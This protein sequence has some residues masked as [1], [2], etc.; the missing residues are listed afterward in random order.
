MTG[1]DSESTF[2]AME[3]YV[4]YGGNVI[5]IDASKPVARAVVIEADRISYVGSDREAFAR[6]PKNAKHID[7][8]GKT[9]IPGFNDNHIHTLAMG[10]FFS[11]P[12]LHGFN[13]PGIIELLKAAFSDVKP[14]KLLFALGWDYPSCP[15]PHRSL[16]DVAFPQNPLVLIQF[17]GHGMWL[18]S[19]AL[20][21]F[22]I[23][24]E[25][26]DPVGGT[27]LRDK[28]GEPTGIL[29]DAATRPIHRVRYRRMH[30][31]RGHSGH[32]LD[33]ALENLREAGITSVQDNT[34]YPVTLRLLKSY[35]RSGLLTCRF[36]CWFL[37]MQPFRSRL[38]QIQ[39]VDGIW[40][41]R[42]P[43]KYFLD[44]TFTTKT[45]YLIEPYSNDGG[46]FGMRDPVFGSLET[47]LIHAAR[48]RR[49]LAFHAIGDRAVHE[50]LNSFGRARQKAP[51]ISDL[52]IR[53]EHAQ[54]IH[55]DDIPRI[56]DLGIIIS[57]QPSALG[58]PE[59]DAA[60]LGKERA[61]AAYPYRS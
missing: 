44:G 28:S 51:H 18:N 40:I 41:S 43:W 11:L 1:N 38:M 3:G 10:E 60:L 22:G 45:A 30:S 53:L 39:P 7:L 20:K 54:L 59:K 55:P 47:L 16:L 4:L 52:R 26:P 50:F 57:A 49:Q 13:G 25:T 8:R 5:T 17:S 33:R 42:G 46:N 15:E 9:L 32:L 58:T 37:G 48:K 56:R 27:I 34:W 36:T 2:T 21:L 35:R 61:E 6:A 29:R 12:R 14:G 23:N 19:A 31:K 24:G